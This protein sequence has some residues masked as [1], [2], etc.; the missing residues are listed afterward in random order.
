MQSAGILL[1]YLAV[2]QQ[3]KVGANVRMG[4]SKHGCVL[5]KEETNAKGCF[6]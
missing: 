1:V 6:A 4:L 3:Y 2:E 5:S